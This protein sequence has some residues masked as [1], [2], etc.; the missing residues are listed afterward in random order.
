MKKSAHFH[1]FSSHFDNQIRPYLINIYG[2][3]KNSCQSIYQN[4]NQKEKYPHILG[5]CGL[6][7]WAGRAKP[8]KT[9]EKINLSQI[10]KSVYFGPEVAPIYGR[11]RQDPRGHAKAGPLPPGG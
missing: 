1:Q 2:D 6:G 10:M 7:E 8:L 9:L 5:A 3:L 11:R 4:D